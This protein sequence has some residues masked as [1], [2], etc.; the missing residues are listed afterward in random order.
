MLAVMGKTASGKTFVREELVKK[1]DYKRI[2]TYTTRPMRKNEKQDVTY[3]FIS[4]DEFLEKINR[5]FFAE[6][7]SHVTNDGIWYYGTALDDCENADDNSVIILTPDGIRDLK[8]KEIDMVTIYLYSNLS[9][10]SRRLAF[11]G[12]KQEEID[13]RVKSDLQDFHDAEM[14]ADRIVYNNLSD[15]IDDVVSGVNYWYKKILKERHNEE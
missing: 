1:H 3:H 6:W 10:I 14:L 13:R 2:I 15:E 5:G 11:R 8:R 4:T 9:T 12:D 7:K